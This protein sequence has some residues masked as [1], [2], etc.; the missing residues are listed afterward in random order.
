MGNIYPQHKAFCIGFMVEGSTSHCN[1]K[2]NIIPMTTYE[3]GSHGRYVNF[4]YYLLQLSPSTDTA[5]RG[6]GTAILMILLQAGDFWMFF[7]QGSLFE[8]MKPTP[9][10]P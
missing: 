10:A 8:K 9:S 5:L 4:C 6:G 1:E 7:G 3:N 2:T